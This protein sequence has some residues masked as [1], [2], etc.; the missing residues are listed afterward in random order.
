MKR[1][2]K[3]PASDIHRVQGESLTE[4]RVLRDAQ[5]LHSCTASKAFDTCA[6]SQLFT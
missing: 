6:A 5:Q 1:C 2:C 4:K 3:F